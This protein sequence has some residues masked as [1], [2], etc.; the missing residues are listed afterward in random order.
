MEPDE[1]EQAFLD[2]GRLGAPAYNLGNERRSGWVGATDTGRILYLIA[3]RRQNKV[4][5]IT[6]R[7]ASPA[8]K[9]RYRQRGK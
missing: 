7:E 3:V 2:P 8:M 4:R 1:A 6:A 5:I 9:R